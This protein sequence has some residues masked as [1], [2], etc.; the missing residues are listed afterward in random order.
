MSRFLSMIAPSGTG[1]PSEPNVCGRFVSNYNGF[2]VAYNENLEISQCLLFS[3]KILYFFDYE[4]GSENGFAVK[5]GGDWYL[6]N[7]GKL[8][9]LNDPEY[10]KDKNVIKCVNYSVL[11]VGR[12]GYRFKDLI[13]SKEIEFERRRYRFLTEIDRKFFFKKLDSP[14]AIVQFNEK[15]HVCKIYEFDGQGFGLTAMYDHFMFFEK[16]SDPAELKIF[17]FKK[18]DIVPQKKEI[19]GSIIKVYK[20]SEVYH[21]FAGEKLFLWDGVSL[22]KHQFAQDITCY[23]AKENFIYIGFKKSAEIHAYEPVTLR[24]IAKKKVTV[25][26]Y[27]PAVFTQSGVRNILT[28]RSVSQTFMNQLEYVVSWDDQEF[29]YNEPWEILTELPIFEETKLPDGRNFYISIQIDA[30]DDYIK[31]IRHSTAIVVDAISRHAV[32]IV[33]SND[34]PY[35]EDFNGQVEVVFEKASNLDANQRKQLAQGMEKIQA[36][37]EIAYKGYAN[38]KLQP[39]EVEVIFKD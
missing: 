27:F 36:D 14:Q 11:E 39:I 18:F 5:D 33:S 32:W 9:L 21:V 30:G 37:Y 16:G 29:F 4:L 26:G 35:S 20:Y 22:S 17:D 31:V 38:G 24:L 28:S 2:R 3:R 12:W 19:N 1:F 7:N 10:V 25:D 13:D 8:E 15:M 23:L 34:R 6:V